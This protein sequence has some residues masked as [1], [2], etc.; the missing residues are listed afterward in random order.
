MEGEVANTFRELEMSLRDI[1]GQK[2]SSLRNDIDRLEKEVGT[3]DSV[4]KKTTTQ[5]TPITFPNTGFFMQSKSNNRFS[6]SPKQAASQERLSGSDT[7][8]NR[9]NQI[10]ASLAQPSFKQRS[11]EE[12]QFAPNTG[13]DSRAYRST[14][15]SYPNPNDFQPRVLLA[16]PSPSQKIANGNFNKDVP[17]GEYKRMSPL[18]REQ[19]VPHSPQNPFSEIEKKL[20]IFDIRNPQRPRS[21]YMPGKKPE[22][23]D[24]PPPVFKPEPTYFAHERISALGSLLS[25]N[26]SPDNPNVESLRFFRQKMRDRFA[27]EGPGRR[28]FLAY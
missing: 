23:L 24:P 2:H 17:R 4:F 1:F 3:G 19:V 21:G 14:K 12:D 5:N 8:A 16:Q 27:K 7:K 13:F 22:F 15:R 25:K 28:T 18:V 11:D 9:V 6:D 26:G 20:A 10:A